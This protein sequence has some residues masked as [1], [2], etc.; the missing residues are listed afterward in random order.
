MARSKDYRRGERTFT[1]PR[2]AAREV[3]RLIK[4]GATPVGTRATMMSVGVMPH[5]SAEKM[6][7]VE[8]R[9]MAEVTDA[10]GGHVEIS[11]SPNPS[12]NPEDP[13]TSGDG[14]DPLT[15]RLRVDWGDGG[16]PYYYYDVPPQVFAAY[17]RAASPGRFI[18][19]VLN[20]YEYGPIE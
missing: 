11:R 10:A 1:D 14:Y 13:R 2:A 8:G 19:A 3:R 20:N 12:I 17:R 7:H 6:D 5:H 18:N 9:L 16:T 4:E 15:Q